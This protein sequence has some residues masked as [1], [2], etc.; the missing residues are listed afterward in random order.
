ME[1][2]KLGYSY[3]EDTGERLI[4]GVNCISQGLVQAA[5]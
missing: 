2:L 5:R 1:S 3:E 4:I